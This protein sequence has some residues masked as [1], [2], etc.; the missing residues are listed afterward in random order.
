MSC[1]LTSFT[2]S[3]MSLAEI[4]MLQVTM[5]LTLW[6]SPQSRKPC[7]L[8]ISLFAMTNALTWNSTTQ[9]PSHFDAQPSIVNETDYIKSQY[10]ELCKAHTLLPL[11]YIALGHK[12]TVHKEKTLF[13]VF[14]LNPMETP[15]F[16]VNES[17]PPSGKYW[18][19]VE[20]TM[21]NIRLC[22]NHELRESIKPVPRSPLMK[23]HALHDLNMLHLK[24]LV[25][26]ILG[27][28][29][30]RA[31]YQMEFISRTEKPEIMFKFCAKLMNDSEEST[32]ND[33][34]KKTD[35]RRDEL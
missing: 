33:K 14:S 6:N 5:W 7:L 16:P 28:H 22:E 10:L 23:E 31:L 30:K 20:Q 21:E 29:E 15:F 2:S 11:I 12:V 26:K 8:L 13:D 3:I 1:L 9:H 24:D 35:N 27:D 4:M 25:L 34:I 18:R 32:E 17:I 19:D